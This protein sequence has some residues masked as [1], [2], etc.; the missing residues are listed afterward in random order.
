MAWF[1][2]IGGLALLGAGLWLLIS[3]V[4]MLRDYDDIDWDGNDDL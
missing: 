3:L 1:A 4:L 2:L